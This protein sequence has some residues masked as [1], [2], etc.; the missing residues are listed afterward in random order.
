MID[1]IRQRDRFAKLLGMEIVSAGD[2]KAVTRLVVRDEHL[3]AMDRVHGGVIFSLADLA[4]ALACNSR[5]VPA[6]GLSVTI[7]YTKAGKMGNTLTA[8]AKEITLGSKVANYIVEIRDETDE[9]L[10]LFQGLAYRKQKWCTDR[11]SS[12]VD[13]SPPS[14]SAAGLRTGWTPRP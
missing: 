11:F 12:N 2:G 13:T 8:E 7:N 1:L 9:I 10:A 3:N 4:F 5:G 6:V 14:P